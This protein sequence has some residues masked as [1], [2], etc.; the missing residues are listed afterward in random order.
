MIHISR[1][2]TDLRPRRCNEHFASTLV[3]MSL[4]YR[5]YKKEEETMLREYKASQD[6]EGLFNR[7]SLLK[8]IKSLGDKY[9]RL[10]EE[11]FNGMVYLPKNELLYTRTHICPMSC[12]HSR[13]KSFWKFDV[14]YSAVPR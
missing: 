1:I 3:Y 12:R 7:P 11:G 6:A 5:N 10:F 8:N 13:H 4:L 14:R 9:Y 2:L